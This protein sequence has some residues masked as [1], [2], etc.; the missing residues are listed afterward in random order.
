MDNSLKNKV[1]QMD[2]QKL[3]HIIE[4][5]ELYAPEVV[6]LAKS[7]VEE[8][9][10]LAEMSKELQAKVEA[11]S[12]DELKQVI[13]EPELYSKDV[14]Q[15]AKHCLK[16]KKKDFSDVPQE[17]K[18]SLSK[19][20]AEQLLDM[21]DEKED[22]LSENIVLYIKDIISNKLNE[23]INIE[24]SSNKENQTPAPESSFESIDT[25]EN[26][27]GEVSVED[28]HYSMW[29]KFFSLI[30]RTVKTDLS[31]KDDKIVITKGTGFSKA[32]KFV[33]TEIM[34]EDITSVKVRR[35]VDTTNLILAAFGI[36]GALIT[37]VWAA[38]FVVAVVLYWGLTA[39]ATISY[40]NDMCE[41]DIPTEFKSDA[42][43]AKGKI[44]LALSQFG[45]KATD[46]TIL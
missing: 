40:K 39:V 32:K 33:E 2:V 15:F 3:N 41:Y 16:N 10:K 30:Y 29:K 9:K 45:K 20:T 26:L 19:M 5:P 22:M 44:D 35:K 42:L 14:V 1:L 24:N 6:E 34:Y 36:I 21:L 25:V 12:I 17:A 43:D 8:L 18:D 38:L 46:T 27:R 31:F 7:R 11:M 23:P 4:N 13:S 28:G 37:Q